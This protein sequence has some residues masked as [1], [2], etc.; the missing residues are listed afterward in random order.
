MAY[1]PPHKR[2]SISG[3]PATSARVITLDSLVAPDDS[4]SCVGGVEEVLELAE[5]T[6]HE[7]ASLLT[8]LGLGKYAQ[9]C[10]YV[11]LRGKDL[12]HCRED[13]LESIGISF[14]PHRMSLLEEVG[15]FVRDGVPMSMLES[16]AAPLPAVPATK[17]APPPRST[18]G[19][20]TD[21]KS[22]AA[23]SETPTWLMQAT[24]QLAEAA[25]A[26]ATAATSPPVDVSEPAA[27]PPPPPPLPAPPAPPPAP[28]LVTVLDQLD[29]M[30]TCGGVS[31]TTDLLNR[32]VDKLEGP[33]AALEVG[34]G[35]R[36]SG[37]SASASASSRS[38][39]SSGAPARRA[40]P[41]PDSLDLISARLES[42][43]LRSEAGTAVRACRSGAA[44]RN[45]ASKTDAWKP[46]GAG[47]GRA[48]GAPP[49]P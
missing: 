40:A 12:K 19:E 34:M 47:M 46:G 13:D 44:A 16:A 28:P 41:E 9:A 3:R 49:R 24:E 43:A 31:G 11:P 15:N 10:L 21:S 6:E 26:T 33:L 14:R 2:G 18:D 20:D 45:A 30:Q 4:I 29:S 5:L 32:L 35:N 36:S 42:L 8:A 23:F 38:V 25:T 48:D 22:S 37:G 1:V 39:P 27:P 7:V 17:L